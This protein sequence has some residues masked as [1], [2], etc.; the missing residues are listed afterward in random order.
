[1]I[2]YYFFLEHVERE[3]ISMLTALNNTDFYTIDRRKILKKKNERRLFVFTRPLSTLDAPA[4]LFLS[5]FFR[6][7]HSS[8]GN[9]FTSGRRLPNYSGKLI[10]LINEPFASIIPRSWIP[11]EPWV[12]LSKPLHP[13]SVSFTG[14][15]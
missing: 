8:R 2:F 1:M 6:R 11:T 15:L 10:P 12:D 14:H 4:T 9:L 7:R 13:F 5:R 3:L